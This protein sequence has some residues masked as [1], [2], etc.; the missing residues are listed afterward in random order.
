MFA[1]INIDNKNY[2]VSLNSLII[3]QK[4]D[5]TVGNIVFFEKLNLIANKEKT[6]IGKPYIDNW[7]VKAE[8]LE[9]I[10]DKKITIFKK[11]RRKNSRR[12]QG[13]RQKSFLLKILTISKK[14]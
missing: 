13:H 11:R 1:I 14:N 3:V 8:V 4:N 6:I 10:I 2:K 9:S 12:K 5:L 7:I